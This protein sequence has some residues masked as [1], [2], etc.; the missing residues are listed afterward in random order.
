MNIHLQALLKDMSD[1]SYRPGEWSE[2]GVWE[3]NKTVSWTAHE[4]ARQLTDTS[5][6]P[7]LYNFIDTSKLAGER[8]HAY[9]I[10][11][12]ITKNTNNEHATKFLLDRLKVE[13]L[14]SNIN[15]ILHRLAE[16]YKPAHLD[17]SMIYKLIEKKGEATRRAGYQAL[18][19]TGQSVEDSLLDLLKKTTEREDIIW[20]IYAL[21]YIGTEKSVTILKKYLKHKKLR[22][23]E[24]VQNTLPRIMIRA[25]QPITEICRLCKV[26]TNFVEYYKDRMDEFTRPG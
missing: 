17:L 9:F 15:L 4:K 16:I 22:V 19:N 26:S 21:G 14:T 18:T 5:Y 24:A 23:R 7:D 20:I 25:G 2:E 11:G 3:N 13:K 10:I 8:A 6:L 12:F 1:D